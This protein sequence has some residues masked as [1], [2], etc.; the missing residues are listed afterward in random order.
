LGVGGGAGHEL[1]GKGEDI[2]AA[3]GGGIEREEMR[4]GAGER[5]EQG[6][7]SCS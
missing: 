2:G 1:F 7:E 5:G 4:L 3:Q 6:E